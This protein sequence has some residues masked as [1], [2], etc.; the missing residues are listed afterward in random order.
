MIEEYVKQDY[1]HLLGLSGFSDVLLTDH[2]SLYDGYVKN[3]NALSELLRS[4]EPGTPKYSEIERRFGWEWN[5]MRLHELYF[6]N[7][8]KEH[9]ELGAGPLREAIEQSFGSFDAWK[10][11]FS[12]IG[13]MRGI[14]WVVLYQDVSSHRLIISWINEH[15]GGHLAGAVPLLVMDVFEHAYLRDY[16]FKRV[17]YIG[18]FFE[19]IYWKAVEARFIA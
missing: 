19:N 16:G 4:E 18:S 8:S 12:S 10:L 9:K 15:D 6:G 5:G 13:L 14:G 3:T 17:D 2:F 7:L 11:A 1:S